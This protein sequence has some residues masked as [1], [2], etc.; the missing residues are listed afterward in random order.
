MLDPTNPH[1]SLNPTNPHPGTPRP[2]LRPTNPE[3]PSLK[4]LQVHITTSADMSMPEAM[5]IPP[6]I[7][8]TAGNPHGPHHMPSMFDQK[9]THNPLPPCH[10]KFT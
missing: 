4:P 2:P 6:P 5:P 8:Y 7:N 1:P 10:C 9:D 3:P